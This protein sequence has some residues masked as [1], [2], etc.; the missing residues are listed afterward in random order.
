MLV[1]CL[2]FPLSYFGYINFRNSVRLERLR[3]DFQI[4]RFTERGEADT[5]AETLYN[6]A[7][8]PWRYIA[9]LFLLTVLVTIGTGFLFWSPQ[10]SDLISFNTLQ[11][12][13]FGF[14]GSYI[15][16]AQLIY[17]RYTTYDLDPDVYFFCCLIII[18][19]VA[20][21][22]IVF[23][24]LVFSTTP[25]ASLEGGVAIFASFIFGYF[26]SLALQWLNRV[27]YQTLKFNQRQSDLLP[28]SLIDGI[29]EFHETRLR[30]NGIDSIQTHDSLDKKAEKGIWRAKER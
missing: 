13:R 25:L 11:A 30:D 16:S 18:V 20:F 24:T 12:M 29:S 15:F 6:F 1:L 10:N 22:Y 9:H 8:A 3:D 17:R 2:Y 4:L 14:I 5:E 21:N 28:L 26:P 19:G 27:A 23:S 7:H